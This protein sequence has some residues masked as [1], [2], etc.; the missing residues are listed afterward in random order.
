MPNNY[1]KCAFVQ[2]KFPT[3]YKT[4]FSNVVVYRMSSFIKCIRIVHIM[5]VLFIQAMFNVAFTCYLN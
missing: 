3:S 2:Y 1:I 4:H 5:F